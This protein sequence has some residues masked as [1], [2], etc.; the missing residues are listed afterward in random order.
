[1]TNLT[2]CRLDLP[3]TFEGDE[4]EGEETSEGEG[5]AESDE[6]FDV[7]VG[8]GSDQQ[9]FEVLHDLMTERSKFFRV[10]RSERW[11]SKAKP[12][13]LPEHDP[14]IFA[15]YLDCLYDRKMPKAPVMANEMRLPPGTDIKVSYEDQERVYAANMKLVNAH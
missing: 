3:A 9:C 4:S 15:L 8:T 10:A 12:T 14:S 5:S 6:Y 1:V 2:S 11:T 7:L 13:E